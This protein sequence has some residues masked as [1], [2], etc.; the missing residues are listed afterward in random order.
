MELFGEKRVF[1]NNRPPERRA[2]RRR[3]RSSRSIQITP[4]HIRIAL[5][6]RRLWVNSNKQNPTCS[7][8]CASVH[9]IPEWALF[10]IRWRGPNSASDISTPRLKKAA[11]RSTPDL[12]FISLPLFG[13]RARAQR[14]HRRRQGSVG[15]GSPPQ[16]QAQRQMA[17]GAQVYPELLAAVVRRAAQGGA[18]GGVN[19]PPLAG[20][21]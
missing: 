21:S 16:S 2:P 1:D 12:R 8:L 5:S 19:A 3:R 10:T 9:A 4:Q 17:D 18:A 20:K 15:G 11:R 13:H 6:P 14:R 7:K